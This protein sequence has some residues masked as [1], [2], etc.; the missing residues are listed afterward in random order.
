MT[1]QLG[2]V[3][4]SPEIFWKWMFMFVRLDDTQGQFWFIKMASMGGRDVWEEGH[5][6]CPCV[7]VCD[8]GLWWLKGTWVMRS[9]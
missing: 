2:G 5:K 7:L 9:E 6:V 1:S 8:K 3:K 4:L